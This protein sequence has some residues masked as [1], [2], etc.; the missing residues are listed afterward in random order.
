MFYLVILMKIILTLLLFTLLLNSTALVAQ[1]APS[2][3]GVYTLDQFSCLSFYREELIPT[4]VTCQFHADQPLDVL[5]EDI[6]SSTSLVLD[7]KSF[8]S[9]GVLRLTQASKATTTTT[10]LNSNLIT[11]PST[12]H[13][14]SAIED[15][16]SYL[17]SFT[18]AAVGTSD[19][20]FTVT[21]KNGVVKQVTISIT[22]V[23]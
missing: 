19:I 13:D 1:T 20:I 8:A 16:F 22:I 5:F 10:N 3:D 4:N 2:S 9:Q 15:S 18:P 12:G 17:Y 23:P 7:E 6:S 14:N 11:T 21:D